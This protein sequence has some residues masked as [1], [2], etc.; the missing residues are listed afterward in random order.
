MKQRESKGAIVK[1]GSAKAIHEELCQLIEDYNAWKN[2]MI[3]CDTTAVNTGRFQGVVKLLQDDITDKGYQ[4]PQYIGCQHHILDLLVKHVLN[5][6]IQEP[7][8]KPELNYSFIDEIT[9]N[10][11][12]LQDQYNEEETSDIDTGHN[13]RWRDDFKFLFE[14][15]QAY[16]YYKG[17]MSLPRINWKKL[18]N[19]HQARWNSRAIYTIMAFFL[20]PNWRSILCKAC[21]FICFEWADAWFHSQHY[22]KPSYQKLLT[23][24]KETKCDKAIKCLKTHWSQEESKLDI[25][26]SNQVAERA[27]KLMEELHGNSKKH[28]F[29]NYKFIGKNDL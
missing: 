15:C 22:F 23:S 2:S 16:R 19:L 27:V 18:P 7:T 28:E 29:L 11:T 3:I 24:L 14:L 13:P 9:S 17:S 20:L 8:T 25:P 12:T 1:N 10:Y 26:R 6:F 4:K 5:F 21:N